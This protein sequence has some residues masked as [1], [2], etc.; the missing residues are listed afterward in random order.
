[1]CIN[2][3]PNDNLVFLYEN[4]LC[5]IFLNLKISTVIFLFSY[6]NTEN[7]NPRQ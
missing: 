6:L 1:V 2:P 3:L 7:D 4:Y 5:V